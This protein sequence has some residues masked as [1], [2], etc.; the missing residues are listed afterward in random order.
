MVRRLII[1]Y[2]NV[3]HCR[4]VYRAEEEEEEEE[5]DD[6]DDAEGEEEVRVF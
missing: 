2:F 1:L 4:H 6:A 3:A 5:E